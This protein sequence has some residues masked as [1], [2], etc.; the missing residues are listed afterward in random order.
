[1]PCHKRTNDYSHVLNNKKYKMTYKYSNTPPFTNALDDSR[2][3]NAG[4]APPTVSVIITNY[5]YGH[6]II[7]TL[8]SVCRQTYPHWECIIVDDCSTDDSKDKINHFLRDPSTPAKKFQFLERYQNGGQMV[9]F[10]QGLNASRGAF[11]MMLDADDLL[12]E[13]F[14]DT[15]IRYHL[16]PWP[17][18]FTS[19]NQYQI[20][21]KDEVI[22][23]DHADLQAKGEVQYI[24]HAT[25]QKGYWIW[26]TASSM[27]FRSDI[28]KLILPSNG[29]PFSICADYYMAHFSNL[30]GNSLL[31]PTIHGCYRRHGQNNFG[32][33]PVLGGINSVGDLAKHPPHD[34]FRKAMVNHIIE[35]YDRFQAI[36]TPK[37][38][39]NFLFRLLSYKE[40]QIV[41]DNKDLFKEKKLFYKKLYIE[42][43]LK[44]LWIPKLFK[45][46]CYAEELRTK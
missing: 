8:Q 42:F 6:Y 18:A 34:D 4:I 15:H 16:G 23:G 32:S 27:V 9:A 25:F 12:L 40:S 5:N 31:I 30:I 2:L 26:A 7:E 44:R 1:M 11:V 3:D 17:V 22:C 20:N 45:K 41:F 28:L 36:L 19:S 38:F 13:D 14:L 43:R 33:H 21:G 24:S 46:I 39:L 37:G 10:M 35:N 29:A